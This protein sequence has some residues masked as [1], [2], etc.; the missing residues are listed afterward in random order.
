[1][2]TA[3]AVPT[4]A[5]PVSDVKVGTEPLPTEKIKQSVERL[6]NSPVEACLDYTADVVIQ[7]GYHSLLAAANIAYSYHFPLALS[8]DHIWLT[9]AQ[10]LAQHINNHAEELRS[11]FVAHEGKATIRVRR[12]EFVRGS[13]ENPWAEVFPA[14]SEVL[15]QFIGDETHGLIVSNFSTTGPVERAASEIV[16]MDAMQSYF[17]YRFI[18][19]CGIPAVILEGT[20]ED[21][22][23]ILVRVKALAQYGLQWWTDAL[24]PILGQFVAASQG[25]ADRSFWS[26][27][28]KREH[29]GSGTLTINGWLNKLIP[30]LKAGESESSFWPE[31][32]VQPRAVT[33][34]N[35]L[36]DDR[37]RC[38]GIT[39][40]MLPGSVSKVPFIW[41]Y[42]FEEFDYEFL[43]GIVAVE[44]DKTTL[45]IRPKTGWAVRS[46]EQ[47]GQTI[48]DGTEFPRLGM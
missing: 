19:V 32:G 42:H 7:P 1:V 20:T 23:R 22:T 41:E 31:G 10:G 11:R 37:S 30:Y 12:D 46:A 43:G 39:H 44:Q 26:G 29:P 45:T 14:F 16:L 8:P 48:G 24:A 2:T 36:L 33:L 21:W 17:E 38:N 35:P 34:R 3:T 4:T 5:V 9:I 13:P 18:S 40:D 15:R 28:W 6:V 27:L 47:A 25:K